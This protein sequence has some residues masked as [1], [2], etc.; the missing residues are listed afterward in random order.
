MSRQFNPWPSPPHDLW[1]DHGKNGPN[2]D[3]DVLGEEEGDDDRCPDCGRLLDN[4][5]CD[6]DEDW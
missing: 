6:E 5:E 3:E 2:D 1:L 4:C